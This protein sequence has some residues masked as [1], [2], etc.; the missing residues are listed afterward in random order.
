MILIFK[1]LIQKQTI[2]VSYYT[3]Y[4]ISDTVDPLKFVDYSTSS[5]EE[6]EAKIVDLL[7]VY[8]SSQIKV[9]QDLTYVIEAVVNQ[10]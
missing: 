7:K 1:I 4:Q 2:P 10:A 5:M 3:F 6:L 8:T 9:I